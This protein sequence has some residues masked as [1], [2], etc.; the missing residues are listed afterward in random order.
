MAK[1]GRGRP[2]GSTN[3][4]K[5]M[6]KVTNARQAYKKPVRNQMMLR[7]AGVVE[8][9]VRVDSDVQANNGHTEENDWEQP[10]PQLLVLYLGQIHQALL[11]RPIFLFAHLAHHK[12]FEAHL[13][14]SAPDIP[15]VY[16]HFDAAQH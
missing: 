15:A 8:T 2:K 1:K 11:Q 4:P 13:H 14:P 16:L 12:L 6:K 7:R 5:V 3:R 9:K 10:P